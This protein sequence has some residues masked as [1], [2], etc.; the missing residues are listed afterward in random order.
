MCSRTPPHTLPADRSVG[1]LLRWATHVL[2]TCLSNAPAGSAETPYLDSLLL[3]GLATGEPTER[4]MA[5]RPDEVLPAAAEAF[6]GYVG[7]RCKGRPVSYIRG[8][9]EFYG[10]DFVV[11]PAVLVPR[12][13]TELL[14][15]IALEMIDAQPAPPHVHDACTGS[16][17]VALTIAAE[18]PSAT[19]TG[20]D[21]DAD[22]L[23]VALTNRQRILASDHVG[24]WQSDLLSHLENECGARSLPRPTIITA[25]PPYLT[26]TEYDAM[27]RSGWPEPAHALR[28]GADGLDMVRRLAEQAVTI[29][30]PGGY[31]LVEI[32][33]QQGPPGREILLRRGFP[34]ASIHQD[35]AG[36]DRVIVGSMA[37][38]VRETTADGTDDRRV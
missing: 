36:R 10:R 8:V 31:L 1:S 37:L 20:S 11:S 19:V 35:L 21:L 12:P 18:R 2:R 4:L 38:E 3:L 28:A 23:A 33:P 6:R 27:D 13:D 9:K 16:G 26:D 29:L 22:A 17:C 25:N 15:E 14:V 5:S 34:N 30:P 32:G 24:L 7:E